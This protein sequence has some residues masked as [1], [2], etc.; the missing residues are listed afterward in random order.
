MEQPGIALIEPIE[1]NTEKVNKIKFRIKKIKERAIVSNL[2]N[3]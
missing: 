3:F 2:L 1:G